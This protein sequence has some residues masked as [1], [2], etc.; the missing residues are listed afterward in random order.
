MDGKAI[1]KTI[2]L[3]SIPAMVQMLLKMSVGMVNKLMVGQLGR[4]SSLARRWGI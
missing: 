4:P 1:R 3:A 2:L